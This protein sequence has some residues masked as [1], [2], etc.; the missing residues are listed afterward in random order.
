VP[1]LL[2]VTNILGHGPHFY[3]EMIHIPL[4]IRVPL[5]PRGNEINGLAQ[6]I[7]IMPTILELLGVEI[8]FFAQGKSLVPF[9]Q[10]KE[11]Y[12]AHEYIYGQTRQQ[13]FIRSL[14]WKLIVDRSRI[15]QETCEGDKLFNIRN[16]PNELYNMQATERKVFTRLK[17][18]VRKHLE[19]LPVYSEKTSTF[20]PYFDKK[21]QDRIKD[22][23]YW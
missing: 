21:T 19:M 11:N 10:D 1:I 13:A 7:D 14:E 9:M 20:P 12:T 16:D 23:G 3:K 5:F 17:K 8:P 22:T 2:N 4:I 6:S 18:N 15:D